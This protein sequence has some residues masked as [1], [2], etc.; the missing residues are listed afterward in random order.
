M[1]FSLPAELIS[2]ED[3]KSVI[4]EL[5][6]YRSQL[7]SRIIKKRV[8]NRLGKTDLELSL[9]AK[10]V[11]SRYFGRSEPTPAGLEQL[12]LTLDNEL[13][14][15]PQ[16]RLVLADVPT[17]KLKRDITDW[18]RQNVSPDLLIDFRFSSS[19]LGGMVI[20]A[21]SHIYDWSYRRQILDNK[22]AFAGVL[23]RV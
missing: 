1:K 7:R 21:G 2:T 9:A 3:V 15:M 16:I 20:S 17:P 19:I 5:K 18:F 4:Y 13:S 14:N 23:R 6:L 10:A 11:L 8:T 22:S 12:L